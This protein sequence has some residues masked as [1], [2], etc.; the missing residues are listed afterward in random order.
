MSSQVS[1]VLGLW[2]WTSP[3]W[4]VAGVAAFLYL[5]SHRGRMSG[6]RPL[7]FAASVTAFLLATVS[8][9]AR[10]SNGYLFSVH[11]VHHILLLLVAPAL[12]L[13]SLDPE[14]VTSALKK[15]PFLSKASALFGKPLLGWAM[16]IGA[17]GFWHLPSLCS[18]SQE[19]GAVSQ[20]QTA[21]LLLMGAAFWWPVIAPVSEQRLHPLQGV[22]YLFSSC[23]AC[24]LIGIYLTFSPVSV[25]PSFAHGMDPLGLRSWIQGDLGLT[26]Q[27]DQ[28]IGGLLMWVP[29]CLIYMSGVFVLF[30]RWYARPDSTLANEGAATAVSKSSHA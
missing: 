23:V 19:I 20:I 21:S 3:A 28:Q 18:A 7:L 11:M 16:G 17:M 22:G 9:L 25:C 15:S 2:N 5:R 29:S 13:M 24:T 6:S 26:P 27:H 14:V 8:P 4:I 30:Y 12:L 1:L 10:L